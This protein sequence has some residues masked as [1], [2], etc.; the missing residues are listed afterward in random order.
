MLAR[1][2]R[3]HGRSSL[4]F[5]YS[6][7]E[8]VRSRFVSLKYAQNTRR[9]TS[10]LAIVVAKKVTKKAPNR[11]RIRRRMYESFRL[12]WSMVKPGYDLV[13]TVFD[14][15][16]GEM[17]PSELTNITTELLTLAKLYK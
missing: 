10:R 9:N 1:A 4:K 17:P 5:V 11:N 13:V 7:G 12:Q 6:S 14:E 8:T 16:V 2:Y 15:R 3:F